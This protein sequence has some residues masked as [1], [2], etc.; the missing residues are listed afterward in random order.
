MR[1]KSSSKPGPKLKPVFRIIKKGT[2]IMVDG[3]SL[4]VGIDSANLG[5]I[6]YFARDARRGGCKLKFEGFK[7]VEV[8]SIL[9]KVRK[10]K[11]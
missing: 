9:K 8:E 2:G 10:K 7:S 3:S 5:L 1:S 6:S 11:K 4:R